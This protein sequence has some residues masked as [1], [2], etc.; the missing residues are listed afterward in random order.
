MMNGNVNSLQIN[1]EQ[2]VHDVE[3]NHTKKTEKND[4]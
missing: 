4:T 2:Q 1:M 3:S